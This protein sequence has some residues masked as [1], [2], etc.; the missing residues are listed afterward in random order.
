MT[1]RPKTNSKNDAERSQ[2]D[3]AY[4]LMF[5]VAADRLRR[6]SPEEIARN[7]GVT[8]LAG[9]DAAAPQAEGSLVIASLNETFTL[10]WPSCGWHEAPENWQSLV[11]LHYL[12]LADGT[13]VLAY[14]PEADTFAEAAGSI[15]AAEG[16][17]KAGSISTAKLITMKQVP[18]GL[19]RGS[20]F[21]F[22]A[23]RSFERILRGCTAEQIRSAASSLG[24]VE[25]DGKGDLCFCF[26]F[27][28]RFPVFLQVWLADEDFPASG[29]LYLDISAGRYLTIED[30][31][32]VGEILIKRFE[33]ACNH[34]K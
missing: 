14:G 21:E 6:H 27:A 24:A 11:L 10:D 33:D 2:S 29:H 17:K 1:E 4:Q 5:D 22:T 9:A 31:V 34:T 16:S 26:P 3:H 19:V 28:P 32:T 20:K 18:D 7:A 23:A 30:I 15:C 25:T 13:P 12:D 8:F